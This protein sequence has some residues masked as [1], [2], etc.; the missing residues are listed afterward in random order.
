[1]ELL[2]RFGP[3]FTEFKGDSTWAI[4]YSSLRLLHM[5]GLGLI[6]AATIG[7]YV[8]VR[9]ACCQHQHLIC[10]A[11]QASGYSILYMSRWRPQCSL[12]L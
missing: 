12:K 5:L 8:G 3:L 1:M 10:Q 11:V 6:T 9:G 4:L 2:D 7:E